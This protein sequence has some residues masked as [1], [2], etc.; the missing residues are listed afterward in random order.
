V[1]LN[2]AEALQ[3]AGDVAGA[4]VHFRAAVAVNGTRAESHNNLGVALASSGAID[5][6]AT[7]FEAALRIRPDYREARDNLAQAR[8]VLGRR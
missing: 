4:V 5:A 2:L 7:E 6:A 8:L 1:Q 3:D